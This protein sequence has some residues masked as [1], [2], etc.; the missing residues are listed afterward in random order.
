[1]K[2]LET[3]RGA[4]FQ[5]NTYESNQFRNNLQAY[6][7]HYDGELINR[8]G[9]EYGD[10]IR[11]LERDLRNL[12][13]AHT[14]NI[15]RIDKILKEGLKPF[16]A[17]G[18]ENYKKSAIFQQDHEHGLV[19]Y[20]FANIGFCPSYG[21]DEGRLTILLDDSV[22]Q[23]KDSFFTFHDLVA[24]TWD[25]DPTFRAYAKKI[26]EQ[27]PKEK[28]PL[29]MLYKI[30]ARTFLKAGKTVDDFLNDTE[31]GFPAAYDPDFK[32]TNSGSP[33]IKIAGTVSPN[34]FKGFVVHDNE[35][36]KFLLEKKVPVTKIIMPTDR[37]D[38]KKLMYEYMRSSSK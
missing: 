35:T 20:V 29:D 36:K 8:F 17:R 5:N 7:N 28:L 31:L 23:R 38:E 9:H 2:F 11:S 18:E 33:E 34:A 25:N 15:N 4:I 26:A 12:A 3:L 14:T 6:L 1:M 32:H 27:L 22:V 37:T 13:I 19:N 21:S 24:A 30:L 16:S 10:R